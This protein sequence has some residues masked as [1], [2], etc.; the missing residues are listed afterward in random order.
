MYALSSG[1]SYANALPPDDCE[2]SK[3]SS[4]LDSA[5]AYIAGLPPRASFPWI[6]MFHSVALKL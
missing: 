5:E 2:T 4:L 3:L 6:F 1:A